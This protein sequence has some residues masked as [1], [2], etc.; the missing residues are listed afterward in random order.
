MST[1]CT[2]E[3]AVRGERRRVV[4]RRTLTLGALAGVVAAASRADHGTAVGEPDARSRVAPAPARP[5]PS[6]SRP[7]SVARPARE[8]PRGGR[9]L[10]PRY[11][12]V[13]FCGAPGSPSLGRLGIG[14]LDTRA[15]EIERLASR[16]AAGRIGQPVFELIAV[17]AQRYPGPDGLYRVRVDPSV[18]ESYL[19]AA[20]R[21]HAIL[22]LNIQPGRA[23]FLDEVRAFDQ[24]LQEPDVG[25]ALDPEWAVGPRQ[26][27]GRVFGRTSGAELNLVTGHVASLVAAAGL[28]DKPLVVHQL[29]ERVI[30]DLGVLRGHRGVAVI[31]SVD[32]IGAPAQKIDTWRRLMR[33]L[34]RTIH[35]GFKLFFEED[36]RG[37]SSLMAPAEVLALTP[38]P[39]YVLYE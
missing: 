16:Y 32:G 17:V 21:H 18:I 31:K 12:L 22:L 37:H 35:P 7:P 28:P 11:R 30:R 1:L 34:P 4:A 10:F 20:R 39:Q 15:A 19:T 6:R 29:A 5:R 33:G 23:H 27:P 9:Q 2:V 25:L 13:G 14:S 3:V 26:V 38:T 36:T 24:W 8:L